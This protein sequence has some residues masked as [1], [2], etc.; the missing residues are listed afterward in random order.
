MTAIDRPFTGIPTFLRQPLLQNSSDLD[1]AAIAVLGIPFDEGSPFLP[2]SRMGPRTIREHTLRFSVNE[3]L[4]DLDCDESY[5]WPEISRGLILDAGDVDVRPANAERTFE[6]ITERVREITAAGVFPVIIGG[7]HSITWPVFAGL[8]TAAHVIQFDAH[9]DYSPV[10]ADLIRTNSNAFRHISEMRNCLSITQVGIRGLR[11]PRSDVAAMRAGGNHV[12]G[13]TKS[14]E[15]G[16]SGIAQLLPEKSKVYVSIDIDAL[17]MSLIPGCVSGEPAGFD[18]SELMA[19]LR[20]ITERHEI[21]GFDLVEVN[22]SLDVRTGATSYLGALIIIG[23]LGYICNQP[24]WKE[25]RSQFYA[26]VDG[27]RW[28]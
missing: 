18:Y 11:N 23:F 7:D 15:L 14:R 13:M 10:D 19:M 24:W 8:A 3:P 21:V 28:G 26:E 25:S 5:L 9:Q 6:I 27:F 20:A 16:P 12:L 22:P 17:D 2:G 4:Y 1:R